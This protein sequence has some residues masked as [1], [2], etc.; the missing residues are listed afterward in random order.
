MGIIPCQKSLESYE[1]L[2]SKHR[3]AVSSLENCNSIFRGK[4][5][6]AVMENFVSKV[7]LY[8]VWRQEGFLQM[9][10]EAYCTAP[11]TQTRIGEHRPF[12]D[13]MT[14]LLFSK[15]AK[16]F[17]VQ[18]IVVPFSEKW[19]HMIL[20]TFWLQEY[21]FLARLSIA[22]ILTVCCPNRFTKL[23]TP[24]RRLENSNIL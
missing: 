18:K 23:H 8:Y 4:Q 17:F 20:E 15:M 7:Q 5:S 9:V 19:S 1:S 11:Y 16:Q 22:Y 3:T 2:F 6:Y 21:E 24:V 13:H 12:Y 14:L 10:V